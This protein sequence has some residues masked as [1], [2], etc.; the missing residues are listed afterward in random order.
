MTKFYPAKIFVEV[1][2]PFNQYSMPAFWL[3]VTRHNKRQ[4]IQFEKAEQ[5]RTR[6]R[7]GRKG[8]L[9]DWELKE[10]KLVN[11]LKTLMEKVDNMKEH[12]GNVSREMDILKIKKKY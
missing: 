11:V 3:K 12:R 8:R 4:R 6:I 5:A 10:K 7:Y 9:T 2:I 1:L